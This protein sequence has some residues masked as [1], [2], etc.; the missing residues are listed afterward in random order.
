MIVIGWL[1][2]ALGVSRSGFTTPHLFLCAWRQLD[3]DELLRDYGH[4]LFVI[5][6]WGIAISH[7][8]KPA[9]D[10]MATMLAHGG[11]DAHLVVM[12]ADD[13]DGLIQDPAEHV[14]ARRRHLSDVADEQ[15]LAREDR[16]LLEFPE[17]LAHVAFAGQHVGPREWLATCRGIAN[18]ILC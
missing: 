11:E 5:A 4:V 3:N 13:Q 1:C 6:Y 7:R 15:P 10:R 9:D 17:L 14:I 18:D 12:I 8:P 2:E 16:P